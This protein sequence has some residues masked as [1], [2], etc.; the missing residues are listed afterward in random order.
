MRIL[1]E[2]ETVKVSE[3]LR[4]AERRLEAAGVD[5]PRIDAQL[6]AA[7]AMG[8]SR[9]VLLAEKEE[10]F[11]AP[12]ADDLLTRREK[13]EPLAYL[14]GI[15]EFYGRPFNITPAVLI[16][17]Q[18][19]ETLVDAFIQLESRESTLSV[20]DL[21]TGSGCIAISIKLECP[22]VELT[23]TDVSLDALEVAE[24]N[25]HHLSAEGIRFLVSDGFAALHGERFGAI[26]TNPPYVA[27]SHPLQPEIRDH[28][29][30]AAVFSGESGMEFF[31]KLAVE[32]IAHLSTAGFLLTEVGDGQAQDARS[33]FEAAGW[34]HKQSFLDLNGTERALCFTIPV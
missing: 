1:M 24:G 17:R 30:A 21:G 3:W 16:P 31:A 9:S 8:V 32:A 18:E 25:A 4:E 15:R 27:A 29:P 22:H 33:R 34:Q 12:S 28:E 14:L 2:N 5:S 26:V 19:T 10:E 20:L 11:E 7:H 6:I 13:R 23:A